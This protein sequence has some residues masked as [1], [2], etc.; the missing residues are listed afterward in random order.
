MEKNNR[1]KKPA[2]PKP[3]AQA[4]ANV[5]PPRNLTPGLCESLRRD[6]MT[7]CLAVAE[8][9]GLTVEGGDLAD[10]DLRHSFEI[11][12]RV[13]IPMEDGAIYSPEKAMFEVLAPHFGLEPSDYG[14]TFKTGGDLHRIVGINPN[15]PKY[16]ISTER[17]SDG[18]GFKMPAENVAMYLQRSDP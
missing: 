2:T 11:A 18:R 16:P 6:M 4:K 17:V 13:G 14:R 8:T 9:H 5:P 3:P 7:A 15:R 1:R 10:I 12:F